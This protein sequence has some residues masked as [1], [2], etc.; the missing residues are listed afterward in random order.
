M[1][2][3]VK[4]P[5]DVSEGFIVRWTHVNTAANAAPWDSSIELSDAVGHLL[6]G[7]QL[8]RVHTDLV[9]WRC[10][11]HAS[12]RRFQSLVALSIMA[13][14]FHY[15]TPGSIPDDLATALKRIRLSVDISSG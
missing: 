4:L 13:V 11:E 1:P 3:Q 12:P 15:K 9:V 7:T 2:G 5:H 6:T 10:C 8:F 14:A